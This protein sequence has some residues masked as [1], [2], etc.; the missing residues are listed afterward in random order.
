VHVTVV[1]AGPAG[2]VAAIAARQA[3]FDC[4]VYEQAPSFARVGGAVGIQGNGLAVLDAIGVLDH[5]RSHVEIITRAAVEAPPGRVVSVA[6]FRE[7]ALAHTGF[8]VALRYDLQETLL[9]AARVAGATILFNK[10]CVRA[11]R[12][13]RRILLS[14]AD[15][16]ATTAEIVLAC[17]GIRSA[18]RETFGITS[19]KRV[20]SEAYLRLVAPIRHPDPDRIGEV[21]AID[22]RRA[23]SFPL[24]RDRTYVFCSVPLGRWQ[25]ILAHSLDEWVASWRDFG[26]PIATLM[27]SI[28]D[29]RSAV[30]DELTDLRAERWHRAGVFLLGDAAHAMTPNLGQGANSAMV[31]A[32][33]LINLLARHGGDVTLAGA[34][35]EQI[36]RPF[37][38]RIQRIALAGGRMASWTSPLARHLR[39]AFFRVG[40]RVG[41]LRRSSMRLTAGF[42]P[43]E[44]P[45]LRPP[46]ARVTALE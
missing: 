22:G 43:R 26:P 30:Y 36:R 10:R 3:G 12:R 5:S 25:S 35:Y 15:G 20:V 8:G 17:D 2:L 9:A 21:W 44:Q 31:D 18:V 28:T 19:R 29:W 32:L 34:K 7:L 11:E 1:G 14:F 13:D 37:V 40:S 16:G 33:V 27:E 46:R 45:W 24:P 4:T 38:T 6:D 39:D 42:N 41:P 23:G